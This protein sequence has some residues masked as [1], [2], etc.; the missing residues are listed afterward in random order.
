MIGN[1]SHGCRCCQL[2]DLLLERLQSA[3]QFRHPLAESDSRLGKAREAEAADRVPV[4]INKW[5][6]CMPHLLLFGPV[7]P[8]PDG[9][10]LLMQSWQIHI[11][12]NHT[13]VIPLG[14][15]RQTFPECIPFTITLQT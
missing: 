5:Q 9:M 6:G 2:L 1:R 11:Q 15:L 12:L 3:D 7:F 4:V 14:I 8:F 10:I 13:E